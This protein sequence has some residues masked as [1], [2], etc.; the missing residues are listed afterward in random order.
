MTFVTV[1]SALTTTS[2]AWL[3][4]GSTSFRFGLWGDVA[5]LVSAAIFLY[6]FVHLLGAHA[7]E[8]AKDARRTAAEG[9]GERDRDRNDHWQANA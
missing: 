1:I 2:L 3:V 9:E 7:N 6:A 4:F 5:F 8:V